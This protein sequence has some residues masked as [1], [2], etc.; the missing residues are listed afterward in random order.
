MKYILFILLFVS[1]SFCG[2]SQNWVPLFTGSTLM[3][4]ADALKNTKDVMRLPKE[5]VIKTSDW[6]GYL[7]NLVLKLNFY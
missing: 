2:S 5:Q 3:V 6:N 4:D 7:K 1:I